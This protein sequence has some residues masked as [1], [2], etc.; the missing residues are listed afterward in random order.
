M[1][2]PHYLL[3]AA[4]L[5]AP[6]LAHI[7]MI[8]P[9]PIK[10]KLNPNTAAGGA[11]YS[12][13]SPLLADGSNYPCKNFHKLLSTPEGTPVETWPAGTVQSMGIGDTTGANHNGGSCQVALSDDSGATFKVIKS[14]IG[15]CPM[16]T[17]QT[18]EV[19]IPKQAKDGKTIFAWT[20]FNKTG[21]REM[22]MNCAVVT[23]TG[24]GSGLTST[25]WP[26]LFTANIGGTC[27][28]TEG[29]DTVFPNPGKNVVTAQANVKLGPPVGE[30][31][32]A[33][34]GSPAPAESPAASAAAPSPT[35]S[36]AAAAPLPGGE[37]AACSCVCGGPSG[38]TVN[39][40]PAAAG[41]SEGAMA[42]RTVPPENLDTSG[43]EGFLDERE[44]AGTGP[45]C[46]AKRRDHMRRHAKSRRSVTAERE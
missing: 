30:C 14:F 11:E 4:L 37:A 26:P 34:A 6:T 1:H 41:V 32:A 22:Y 42:A 27:K 36:P 12:Y 7:A 15:A 31:G 13:S 24:G 10:H 21:Q 5:A 18:L 28:T 20:W 9:F 45:T 16:S 33:G 43:R 44:E 40:V 35:L 8:K 29:I 39:I 25:E 17:G 3:I 2:T 38:Y 23:I 46:G 19:E